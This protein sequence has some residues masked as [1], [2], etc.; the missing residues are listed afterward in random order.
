MEKKY[1]LVKEE[2]MIVDAIYT[3]YRVKALRDF[4]EIYE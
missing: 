2:S 1:E 3:V 4:D